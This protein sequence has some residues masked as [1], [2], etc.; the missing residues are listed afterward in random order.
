M[1]ETLDSKKIERAEAFARKCH[2][3]QLRKGAAREPYTVHLEEVVGIVKAQGGG[4]VDICAA[5][6]HDTVEDCP[7]T[8]FA[9]IETSFGAEVADVVRQ[10]TDDK[11]LDKAERK[12]MQI[13]NAAHKS[14]SAC[15][16]KIADKTSNLNSI[17]KSPPEG[18][19][20]ERRSEYVTWAAEVVNALAYKPEG[21]LEKFLIA[22]DQ[23]EIANASNCLTTRQAESV[24]LRVLQRRAERLGASAEK[25]REF[26][27]RFLAGA[28]G[29]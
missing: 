29:R 23:A 12:R 13:V 4:E 28:L 17:A 8:S 11:R 6:L 27:E 14:R 26:L 5:W 24:S 10:L 18:W 9:D 3:G 22:I 20:F 16:V 21:A 7:P 2:E 15:L 19:S 1:S 25:T